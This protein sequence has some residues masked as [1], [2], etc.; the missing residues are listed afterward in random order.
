[1]KVNCLSCGHSVDLRGDYDDYNGQVRCFVCG[2]LLT[3]RTEDGRIRNVALSPRAAAGDNAGQAHGLQP[4]GV[5]GL[6]G[7]QNDTAAAGAFSGKD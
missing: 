4:V 5:S 2:A 3:I 7:F 1:M 6:P